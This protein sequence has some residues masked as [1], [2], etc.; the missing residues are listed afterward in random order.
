MNDKKIL[1]SLIAAE[2][3][4]IGAILLDSKHYSDVKKYIHSPDVFYN[5]LNR[6]IWKSIE[7]QI[8]NRDEPTIIKTV[9]MLD[10]ARWEKYEVGYTITGYVE[11]VVTTA[12]TEQKAKIVL[13]KYILRR[14][15]SESRRIERKVMENGIGAND[16]VE[17]INMAFNSISNNLPVEHINIDDIIKNT[18]SIIYETENLV[19]SGLSFID[20]CIGGFTRKEVSIIAGRPGHGKTTTALNIVLNM[21]KDGYRVAVI[22]REMPNEEVMKKFICMHDPSI[23]YRNL[24]FG[25]ID[26]L[27][28]EKID[29]A[30]KELKILFDDKLFMYD[31]IRDFATSAKELR[32]IQPDIVMDDYVQLIKPMNPSNDRRLQIEQVVND[33]KWMAKNYN[34]VVLL[35]S[36]LNRDIEHRADPIPRMSDLSE[37]GSLEQTAE[38]ILF[39]YYEYK[40]K[41][42]HA[43]LGDLG[44]KIILGKNRYGINRS[45]NCGFFGDACTIT[46]TYEE[47]VSL[48]NLRQHNNKE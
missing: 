39:C 25:V 40:V 12:H 7:K 27:T 22:N 41:Y 20:E 17:Y 45:M 36:Q 46:S 28:G 9:D 44:Y 31:N 14:C 48:K 3:D 8:L 19:P 13:D 29:K 33:Y 23:S 47:A 34:M 26:E 32:K 37:G 21:I 1:P 4:V 15:I 24:R 2:N 5:E 42:D 38:M 18:M 6:E 16:I 35:V 43:S 10:K 11:N 30:L